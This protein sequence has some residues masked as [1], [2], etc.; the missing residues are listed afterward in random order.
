MCIRRFLCLIVRFSY[1]CIYL[2]DILRVM[3][4]SIVRQGLDLVAN[5]CSPFQRRLHGRIRNA[6][7][8]LIT[9][10]ISFIKITNSR[11][12]IT[13]PCGIPLV[14]SCQDENELL[15]LTR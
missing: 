7:E 9:S 14:T 3:R 8:L 5:L 10:G 12:P 2:G 6:S 13:D 11:G 1:G 15:P 4:L